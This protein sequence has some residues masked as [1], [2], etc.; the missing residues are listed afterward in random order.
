MHPEW[1]ITP[2]QKRS[3]ATLFIFV[4]IQVEWETVMTKNIYVLC[5]HMYMYYKNNIGGL[6]LH[7][8]HAMTGESFQASWNGFKYIYP[9]IVFRHSMFYYVYHIDFIHILQVFT[10]L[11]FRF[12][13]T[14][15]ELVL[16][17]SCSFTKYVIYSLSHFLSFQVRYCFC[18][19]DM[20]WTL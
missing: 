1:P 5:F 14:L 13:D 2:V 18:S 10:S 9:Q 15:G 4:V 12:L 17:L 19:F 6:W 7:L 11:C 16:W 20:W 3:I 8:G